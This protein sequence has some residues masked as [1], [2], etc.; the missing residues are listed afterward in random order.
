MY[1]VWKSP[2][3]NLGKK[4]I[5]KILTCL[6]ELANQCLCHMLELAPCHGKE[7]E[8]SEKCWPFKAGRSPLQQTSEYLIDPTCIFWIGAMIRTTGP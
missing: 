1:I 6:L 5:T 7:K 3:A 4:L 2:K 8:M